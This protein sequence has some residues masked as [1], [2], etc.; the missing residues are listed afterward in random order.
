MVSP[1]PP[2]IWAHQKYGSYCHICGS[3]PHHPKRGI[4]K[5]AL[6]LHLR[7]EKERTTTLGYIIIRSRHCVDRRRSSRVMTRLDSNGYHHRRIG[8]RNI[9]MKEDIQGH[10]PKDKKT[11]MTTSTMTSSIMDHILTCSISHGSSATTTCFW[12]I[13]DIITSILAY[14]DS[15][16]SSSNGKQQHIN[17]KQQREETDDNNIKQNPWLNNKDLQHSHIKVQQKS[18]IKHHLVGDNS[19]NHHIHSNTNMFDISDTESTSSELITLTE[20]NI[21][22][23]ACSISTSSTNTNTI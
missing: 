11:S 7:K 3:S 8:E 20:A 12:V 10:E 21:M 14:L 23:A 6:H 1:L 2:L 5:R 16:R 18:S 13:D 9:K 19:Y 15:S 4:S 17:I 22:S